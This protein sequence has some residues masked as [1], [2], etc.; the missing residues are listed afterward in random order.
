MNLLIIFF[1][2]LLLYTFRPVCKKEVPKSEP[3]KIEKR[4]QKI[5]EK[6]ILEKEN[7]DAYVYNEVNITN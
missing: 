5:A 4:Y 7:D 1:L 6:K 3:V 2:L